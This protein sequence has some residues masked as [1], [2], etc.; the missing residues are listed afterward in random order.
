M[1]VKRTSAT[2]ACAKPGSSAT[3]SDTVCC[4]PGPFLA[5]AARGKRARDWGRV[6]RLGTGGRSGEKTVGV[7]G[8]RLSQA[9]WRRPAR[10][11]RSTS[12][13]RAL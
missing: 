2:A 10:A 5:C 7:P 3:A 8:R 4:C 1:R 12:A 13:R 6:G 11:A 9:A